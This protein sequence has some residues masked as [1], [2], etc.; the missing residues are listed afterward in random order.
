MLL[1]MEV[2]ADE[3]WPEYGLYNDVGGVEVEITP[4]QLRHYIEVSKQWENVQGW[5][6]GLYET[7]E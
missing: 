5:L 3:R 2:D 1:K 7:K 6:R 4:Q